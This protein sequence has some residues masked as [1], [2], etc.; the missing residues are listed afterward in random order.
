MGH[1]PYIYVVGFFAFGFICCFLTAYALGRGRMIE[2]KP[3]VL[4]F[5]VTETL[6]AV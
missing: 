3:E 4:N 1:S 2:V 6:P 5:S